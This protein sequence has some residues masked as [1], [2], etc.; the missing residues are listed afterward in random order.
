M[1]LHERDELGLNGVYGILVGSVSE[2]IQMDVQGCFADY[3]H[4]QQV[5]K[6][7]RNALLHSTIKMQFDTLVI[8][9]YSRIEFQ[10]SSALSNHYLAAIGN[11]FYQLEES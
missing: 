1:V 3:S 7:V 11:G 8:R 5:F 6:V 4:Q 10:H 2:S 9:H